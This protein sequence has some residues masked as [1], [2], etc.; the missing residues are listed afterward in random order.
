MSLLKDRTTLFYFPEIPLNNFFS[1]LAS[2]VMQ[3][4]IGS[5]GSENFKGT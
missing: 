4:C 2:A 5:Y 3:I 1:T